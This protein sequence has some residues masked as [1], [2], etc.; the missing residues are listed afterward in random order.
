MLDN[1]FNNNLLRFFLYIGYY[2]NLFMDKGILY[3]YGPTGIFKSFNILSYKS[4]TLSSNNYS[5]IDNNYY[6]Y[7]DK[8]EIRHFNFYLFFIF[9]NILLF[10]LIYYIFNISIIHLTI[11]F[12]I[13]I[14]S[15]PFII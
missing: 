15:I 13:F 10:I 5:L 3:I 8:N 14:I 11:L 9:L 7:N 2:L 12:F 1:I 6:E 4:I